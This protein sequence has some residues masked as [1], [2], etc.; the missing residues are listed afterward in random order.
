[1]IVAVDSHCDLIHHS[2]TLVGSLTF[3]QM[4]E[5]KFFFKLYESLLNYCAKRREVF[6]LNF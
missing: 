5:V 2:F 4:F 3:N 1:M 6:A